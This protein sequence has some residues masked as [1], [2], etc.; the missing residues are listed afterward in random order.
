MFLRLAG[1][2]LSA[3][4][5]VLG[6]IAG[7][8]VGIVFLRSGFSLGKVESVW[9]P[10][11]LLMPIGMTVLL[12][13]VV[14]YD[15]EVVLA[16]PPKF[17]ALGA[18]LLIGFIAQRSRFCIIGSFRNS[19]IMRRAS[20]LLGIG[21]LILSAALVN[22]IL[23]QFRL[24]FSGQPFA[25]T[26]ILWGILGAFLGGLA[27]TLAGACPT[28]QLLLAS[29]GDVD[30]SAFLLGMLAATWLSQ[31]VGYVVMPDITF[32]DTVLVGG[33][34]LVGKGLVIAGLMVCALMGV[35]VLR[36]AKRDDLPG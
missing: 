29:E 15:G 16:R 8:S 7:I 25:H 12:V 19:I 5:G 27:F 36:R 18:G 24:G 11:G 34:N 9:K 14:A 35:Y 6:L 31:H 13:W 1:G 17:L 20:P 32:L 26:N 23:G 21:G 22:L 30:A 10:I 2:D 4:I 28:R 3:I 33:P